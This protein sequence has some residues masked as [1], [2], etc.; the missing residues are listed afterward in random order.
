MNN[1]VHGIIHAYHGY[2]E[3]RELGSKRTGASMPFCGRYRLIDFAMSSMM[4]AGIHDV[5]I[6]MQKGYQSLLDHMGSGR[7]WNMERHTGGLTMLPPYGLPDATKGVYAGCMEALNAVRT[8]LRD[9]RQP[10]V[11]LA[12]GD[13]CASI[14]LEKAINQ[15][16]STGVDVTAVCTSAPISSV[17]HSYI[18]GKNSIAEQLLCLQTDNVGVQS[19]ETYIMSKT[20]LTELVEWC[21]HRGCIHLHRDAIMHLMNEGKKIGVYMH[22]GYARLIVNVNGYYEANMDMLN[23]ANRDLLFPEDRHVTTR[24]RINVSTYYGDGA[25]VKTSL[26]ADGCVVEGSIENCVLFPGVKLAAGSVLKNCIIMNDTVIGSNVELNCVIADKDV[27]VSSYV[28]LT[29]NSKLPLVI[30]K[31]SRI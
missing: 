31:R 25:K 28:S 22:D 24:E 23:P 29:G 16:I 30:P 3:L 15:H 5:G 20:L 13:M 6:I 21:A 10:Y 12:R 4:N 18:V 7:D 11:V 17:H 1:K 2:A 8:Y 14:D 9:I 27:N 26:V 19:L